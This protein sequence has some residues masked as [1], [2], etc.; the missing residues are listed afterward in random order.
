LDGE[1]IK[2]KSAYNTGALYSF[3]GSIF[4]KITVPVIFIMWLR[5]EVPRFDF[6]GPAIG[7]WCGHIFDMKNRTRMTRIER[8]FMDKKIWI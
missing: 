8:V 5:A 7:L 1:S 3:V 4:Y 6:G 2:I